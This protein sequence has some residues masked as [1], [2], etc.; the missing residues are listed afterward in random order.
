MVAKDKTLFRKQADDN[1]RLRASRGA[2]CGLPP[3]GG[4]E[5]RRGDPSFDFAQDGEPVEPRGRLWSKKTGGDKP[6]P[7]EKIPW[8]NLK[9]YTPEILY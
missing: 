6:L 8:V 7:Y 1:I 2:P 9:V 4:K 5:T 3:G